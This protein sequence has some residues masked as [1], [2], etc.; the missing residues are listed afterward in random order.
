MLHLM[1]FVIHLFCF[2]GKCFL[3]YVVFKLYVC[4]THTS[5]VWRSVIEL[6]HETVLVVPVCKY[7]ITVVFILE[8]NWPKTKQKITPT[9]AYYA[10]YSF[11]LF[12]KGHSCNAQS[13]PQQTGL[14]IFWC[15]ITVGDMGQGISW[16]VLG[17]SLLINNVSLFQPPLPFIYTHPCK[18]VF[19]HFSRKKDTGPNSKVTTLFEI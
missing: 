17:A 14:Q 15:K 6:I 5:A 13:K 4:R 16:A 18:F 7:S 11:N 2:V 1:D 9:G 10:C 19:C 12:G 8:M 3:I